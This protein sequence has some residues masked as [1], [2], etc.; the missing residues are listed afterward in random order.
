MPTAGKKE[1]K[2]TPATQGGAKT[3]L[4]PGRQYSK[5]TFIRIF[6]GTTLI[7]LAV[8]LVSVL[9]L[10]NL[11]RDVV[12][13]ESYKKSID[14]LK[15]TQS[16]FGSLHS[17]IIPSFFQ[18][19]SEEMVNRLI[20]ADTPT[21][22][23]VSDGLD[24]LDEIMA[25]FTLFQSIYIYNNRN[26]RYFSTINGS[27]GTQ[28]S[29]FALS[30]LLFNIQEYG[31]Y[32]YIPR[33]MTY[34][35]N[36]NV[37]REDFARL[38]T[39]NVLSVVVGNAPA[40]GQI[41]N[42][43]LVIN[44]SEDKIRRSLLGTQSAPDSDLLVLSDRGIILTHPD[45]QR[46]GEDISRQAFVRRI[47]DGGEEGAFI[48]AIDGEE[49]LISYTTHRYWG[50]RFVN[51]TPTAGVFAGLNVLVERTIL[52]CV[53]LMIGVL[54]VSFFSSMRIYLPLHR[55]FQSSLAMREK[56]KGPAPEQ[57]AHKPSDLQ[58]LDRTF[59]YVVKK[60]DALED[61]M[62]QTGE[63]YKQE[64][65]KALLL[66][67]IDSEEIE[68]HR[69]L[70]GRELTGGPFLMAV[71]RLDRFDLL[72][73]LHTS[74][75]LGKLFRIIR[76][77]AFHYNAALK[78]LFI[79]M[80]KDQAC[81]IYNLDGAAAPPEEARRAI[82][83]SLTALQTAVFRE[84]NCTCTVALSGRIT[85]FR[86]FC[87]A[88]TQ[89]VALTQFRFR[90]GYNRI[91]EP[92]MCPNE[93]KEDYVFPEEKLKHLLNNL[94]LGKVSHLEEQLD[95]ILEGVRKREYEDF[96]HMVGFIAYH[97][98]QY[99][100]KIKDNLQT[101]YDELKGYIREITASET[102]EELKK[103]LLELFSLVN[104]L[105][106]QKKSRRTEDRAESIRKHIDAHFRDPALSVDS[107]A[108]GMGVSSCYIRFLFRKVFEISAS[109]Y[110]NKLRLEYCK[111]RLRST[112]N[113]VK[114]IYR[115]AGYYNYSYFFTLFKKETGLTPNQF[116]H[117][118]IDS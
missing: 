57:S 101:Q 115:E 12:A 79:Q 18:I 99:L 78:K 64:V 91:I 69:D 109:E 26:G 27:E 73:E 28:C 30:N 82:V 85:D 88:Y 117:Q 59:R 20:H 118:E 75:E 84:L 4:Q 74:D 7:A 107:L 105:V 67:D 48:E 33:K 29:D 60:A 2:N 97:T 112:R 95:D 14:L 19:E 31:V 63:L 43:A 37:F 23:E 25:S 81:V 104:E 94:K 51:I 111:D 114:K 40:P 90:F 93:N 52:L 35:I 21:N 66:G 39:E 13:E 113:T 98:A 100:G 65:V 47:L 16:I 5:K 8:L 55:F 44:I 34:R 41:I 49:S 72:S 80:K 116:R 45:P 102:L 50:W 61:Y 42:G 71:I 32:R 6:T 76:E 46:F 54:L 11:F 70:I 3:I 10:Y 22:I 17:W 89:C 83:A 24:R 86:D 58:Y 68:H 96:Q 77:M 87:S 36:A 106:L 56:M 110:I 103:K 92:D 38:A 15:Q 1:Y 108:A 9:V 53:A 62:G